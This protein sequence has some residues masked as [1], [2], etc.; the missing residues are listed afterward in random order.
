MGAVVAVPDGDSF[1]V[2]EDE[3]GVEGGEPGGV[4][5]GV[6]LEERCE[7]GFE[8]SGVWRCFAGVDVLVECVNLS[9]LVSNELKVD[10]WR[11]GQLTSRS[12][13]GTKSSGLSV[14][15]KVVE[16]CI[17]G[18]TSSVQLR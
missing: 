5:E 11:L 16:T 14:Y 4:C 10:T 12:F 9:A 7:E 2:Q 8:A 6:G 17:A 13:A 18:A 3:G 15:L 1:G